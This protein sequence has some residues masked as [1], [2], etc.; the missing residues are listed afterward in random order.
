MLNNGIKYKVEPAGL[1]CRGLV[2]QVVKGCL[3]KVVLIMI[4]AAV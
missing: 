1:I 3:G 4:L 2:T